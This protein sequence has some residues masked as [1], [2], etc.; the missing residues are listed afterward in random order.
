MDNKA[1]DCAKRYLK[2]NDRI[3]V[4]LKYTKYPTEGYYQDDRYDNKL[5][6]KLDNDSMFEVAINQVRSIFVT[7]GGKTLKWKN[8]R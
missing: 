3:L 6:M 4:F 1:F 8:T 5:L 2:H 7:R